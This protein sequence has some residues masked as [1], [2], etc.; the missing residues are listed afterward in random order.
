MNCQQIQLGGGRRLTRDFPQGVSKLAKIVVFWRDRYLD[1]RGFDETVK[2]M[3]VALLHSQFR[4]LP[5]C[6]K[7]FQLKKIRMVQGKHR[8]ESKVHQQECCRGE[9]EMW[10]VRDNSQNFK[11]P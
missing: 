5:T 7:R 8:L 9:V 4:S 6:R 11:Q 1:R 2:P 3:T 10:L